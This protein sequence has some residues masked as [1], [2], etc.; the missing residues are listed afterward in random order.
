MSRILFRFSVILC[1]VWC[2]SFEMFAVAILLLFSSV[3]FWET[4]RFK[5]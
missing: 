3:T 2:D 4:G 1:G 5:M